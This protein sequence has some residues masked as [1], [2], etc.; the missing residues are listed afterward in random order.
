MDSSVAGE[1]E[2]FS[3]HGK[4]PEAGDG[5]SDGNPLGATDND[6]IGKLVG[7][8]GSATLGDSVSSDDFSMEGCEVV[9]SR[10]TSEEYSVTEEG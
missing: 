9:T 6:P 5:F 2:G 1:F 3:V 4:T 8:K 7:K 10:G